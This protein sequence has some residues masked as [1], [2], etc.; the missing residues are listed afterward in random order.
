M[1]QPLTPPSVRWTDADGFFEQLLDAHQGLSPAQSA[2]L[3][4]RLV[5]VL[6]HEVGDAQALSRCLSIAQEAMPTQPQGPLGDA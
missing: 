6:G 2:D 4:A 3:N 5:L 1:T